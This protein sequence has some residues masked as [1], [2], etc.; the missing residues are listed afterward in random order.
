MIRYFLP[1]TIIGVVL[2]TQ[3]DLIK[4]LNSLSPFP[5]R[6]GL[7]VAYSVPQIDELEQSV[8]QQVNEYRASQNLPPLKLDPRISQQCQLHSQSMAKGEVK[9]SHA[10]S[11][12]RFQTIAQDI[13]YRTIAENVAYNSGYVDP[14]K[15]AVEGWI[16]SEGHRQNMEGDFNLTGIGIVRNAK[17]EYYFTQIFV[18]SQ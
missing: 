9:F 6:S 16:K 15:K 7:P 12:Q 17:G 14:G 18:R 4:Q 2:L 8:F 13:R 1:L 10:G 5:E 11:K 3:T